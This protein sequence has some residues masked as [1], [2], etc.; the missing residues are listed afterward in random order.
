MGREVSIGMTLPDTLE[1][2]HQLLEI[3]DHTFPLA[4][5]VVSA[6]N[7]IVLGCQT[8]RL[9]SNVVVWYGF[10]KVGICLFV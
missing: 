3:K 1:T 5:I 6:C 10:A 4:H 7:F 2:C 8:K 9:S